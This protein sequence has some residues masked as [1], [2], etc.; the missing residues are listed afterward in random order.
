LQSISVI[1]FNDNPI[2][3][4]QISAGFTIRGFSS[5]WRSMRSTL[6]MTIALCLQWS[7]DGASSASGLV[8]SLGLEIQFQI[9]DFR[10]QVSCDCESSLGNGQIELCFSS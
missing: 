9:G 6:E 5:L 4:D 10:T 7:V 2:S 8:E 3:F 1:A